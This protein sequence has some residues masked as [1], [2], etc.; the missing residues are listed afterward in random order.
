MPIIREPRI[1][2]Q[3]VR[4]HPDRL[5]VFGDNLARVGYGGQAREMRDEPNAVGI[6]TKKLPTMTENAFFSDAD[7]AGFRAAAAPEFERLAL[8]LRAGG[9]VVWP[10]AGIGTGLADLRLRAPRVWGS[11]QRAIAKLEG[12]ADGRL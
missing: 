8:H 1:T 11:L 5:F 12:I 9:T 6:P 3:M 10:E 2:R 4:E 7:V